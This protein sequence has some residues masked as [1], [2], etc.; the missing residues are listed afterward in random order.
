M[1]GAAVNAGDDA[2]MAADELRA[3]REK[4]PAAVVA[5]EE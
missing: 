5:F 4:V 1:L 2:E 3:D